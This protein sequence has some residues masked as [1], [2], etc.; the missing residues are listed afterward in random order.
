M[1]FSS[2]GDIDILSFEYFIMKFIKGDNTMKTKKYIPI[3]VVLITIII[4]NFLFQKSIET[5]HHI[6]IMN[7]I[8]IID[9]GHGGG[10]PGKPGKY[11]KH[12]DEL[13]LEIATKLRDLVDESGGISLMTREDDSLSDNN[14]MKDLKNRVLLGNN[15]K[16]DIFISIHLNSYPET[17]Y[18]GAQV[19]YQK[20]SPQGK[21]LAKLIQ[22]ELKKT[23]DPK[24]DRM[25]KETSTFFV[26]R[27]A[28][29]P[30][31]IV[32]CGF[33]SNPGE[34]RLLNDKKY[35]YRIAWAIYKGISR[36][37]KETA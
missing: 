2:Y 21:L 9:P 30:A 28:K 33:M 17:Q 1:F 32:E 36:Y 27:H 18:K 29:M 24:N 14:L 8:I 15:I 23:L 37:F 13:N 5:F 35:Q 22:D 4:L 3:I 6:P 31:V 12:E 19:F 7:K 20:N 25:A 11:G 16:G 26:L 10:D 34:E